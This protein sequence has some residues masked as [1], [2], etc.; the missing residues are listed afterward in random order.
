MKL[1]CI[2]IP[3]VQMYK[4]IVMAFDIKKLLLHSGAQK[5]K[6]KFIKLTKKLINNRK[7]FSYIIFNFFL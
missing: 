1:Q 7:A 4:S 3:E 5:C 2:C 6:Y